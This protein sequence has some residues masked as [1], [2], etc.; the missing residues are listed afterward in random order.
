MKLNFKKEGYTFRF[1]K[2]GNLLYFYHPE[3]L[4]IFKKEQ[5]SD[6]VYESPSLYLKTDDWDY[7]FA[8]NLKDGKGDRPTQ[9]RVY[10]INS[11]LKRA[12]YWL[13]PKGI[14]NLVKLIESL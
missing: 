8:S 6:W 5:I 11:S 10:N 4:I 7:I 1:V 14:S 13:C 3:G 2:D 9:N 12:E